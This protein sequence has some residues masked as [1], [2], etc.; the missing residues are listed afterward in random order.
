LETERVTRTSALLDLRARGVL[1]GPDMNNYHLVRACT[2]HSRM[3]TQTRLQ[4]CADA[5]ARYYTAEHVETIMRRAAAS[6]LSRRKIRDVLTTFSGSVRRKVRTQRRYGMP[7]PS[8]LEFYPRAIAE[9]AAVM[10][11]GGLLWWRYYSMMRRIHRD[12]ANPLISTKHCDRIQARTRPPHLLKCLPTRFLTPMV[13]RCA[14]RRWHSYTETW[15]GLL[16]NNV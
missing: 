2:D 14:L 5:W 10:T 7:I 11:Q 8:P 9:C 1:M 12:P 6:R 16:S 3:S 4:V 13:G 15:I